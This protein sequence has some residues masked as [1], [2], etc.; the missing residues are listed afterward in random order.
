MAEIRRLISLPER[1]EDGNKGSFGCVT[2]V[3]GCEN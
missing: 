3:G 2:V 1:A